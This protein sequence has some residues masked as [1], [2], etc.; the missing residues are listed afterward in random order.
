MTIE[1]ILILMLVAFILGLIAGV[2]M[3]RPTMFR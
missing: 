1:E 2:S 3:T